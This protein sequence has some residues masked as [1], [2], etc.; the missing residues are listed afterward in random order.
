MSATTPAPLCTLILPNGKRCGS[1]AL[2]G[3]RFC[4]HH[5]GKHLDYTRDRRLAGRLERLSN[6]YDEM[7]T[8]DLLLT[9]HRQL[10]TL[11]KTLSRFPEVA[12]ILTYTL[13]RLNAITAL[14]SLLN[15]YL[16]RNQKFAASSKAAV[17][18]S[19]SSTQNRQNQ[20]L[21][22]ENHNRTLNQINNLATA[23]GSHSGRPPQPSAPHRTAQLP[24]RT[25]SELR[26]A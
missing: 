19:T 8:A 7:K 23:S 17:A 24:P 3:K 15:D 13:D 6:Q 12:H 26:G 22:P 18:E 14:E 9:L 11:P 16:Q 2:R 1:P 4:Y 5:S 10:G 21:D 20:Q 25:S